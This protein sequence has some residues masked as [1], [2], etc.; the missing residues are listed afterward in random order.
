MSWSTV[1][2]E[3][4]FLDP[5][6]APREEYLEEDV[7]RLLALLAADGKGEPWRG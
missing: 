2:L 5:V 3:A 1:G 7:P 6:A 4:L